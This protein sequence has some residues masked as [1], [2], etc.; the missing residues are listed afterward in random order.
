MSQCLNYKIF[1]GGIILSVNVALYRC[2]CG[3]SKMMCNRRMLEKYF[4]C[5][6]C[7]TL[8][9]I[10]MENDMSKYPDSLIAGVFIW[11]SQ[12]MKE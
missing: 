9:N 5:P 12:G 11:D 6:E 4:K 2:E 3:K 1:I 10:E 7:D 8:V